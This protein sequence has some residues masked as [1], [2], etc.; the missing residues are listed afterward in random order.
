MRIFKKIPELQSYLAEQRASG[1][2]V[3]FCP[4]MGSLHEG[5]LSLV[6]NCKRQYDICVVSI[7]VNALQFN[8]KEDLVKYPR[9]EKSDIEKLESA[10]ADVA[11]L[12]DHEDMYSHDPV[13][14]FSFGHLEKIMEGAN[15][16]GHFNGVGIVVS[17]L[18]N[19]VQPDAAFFGQKD[20][21][22]FKIIE[23]LIKDLYFPVKLFMV[24]TSR[25]ADG[26]ARSSRNQLLTEVYR[27]EATILYKVLSACQ[28]EVVSGKRNYEEICNQGM[29]EIEAS[30]NIIPEYLVCVDMIEFKKPENEENYHQLAFCVAAQAGK[31]RLIDNVIFELN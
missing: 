5:H 24:P 30:S 9:Q 31:I 7:F 25:E 8:N 14:T 15:R 23:R 21:Q 17:K 16:P 13:I 19:I 1:K 10:Q 18:F 20:L 6:E 3:G 28:K 2:T 22:Q 26:L 12:P 11:F 29:K 27:K 4:T